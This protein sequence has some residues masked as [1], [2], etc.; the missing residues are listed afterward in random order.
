MAEKTG[1]K[2]INRRVGRIKEGVCK[3]KIFEYKNFRYTSR[4]NIRQS[5]LFPESEYGVS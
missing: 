5:N 4:Y 2:N 3:K 1:K